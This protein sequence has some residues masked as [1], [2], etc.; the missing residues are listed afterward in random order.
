MHLS[1]RSELLWHVSQFD[2]ELCFQ[3]T[4]FL[5]QLPHNP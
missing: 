4:Q 1:Y 3:M 2:I 5:S